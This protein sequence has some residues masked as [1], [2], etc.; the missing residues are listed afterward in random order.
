MV[1]FVVHVSVFFSLKNH[2][3]LPQ[4]NICFWILAGRKAC[5]RLVALLAPWQ[6]TPLFILFTLTNYTGLAW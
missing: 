2:L 3:K 6:V 4:L 5:P 1:S